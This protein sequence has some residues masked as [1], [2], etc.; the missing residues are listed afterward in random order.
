VPEFAT[1]KDLPSVDARGSLDRGRGS[2][3]VVP[4]VVGCTLFMQTLDSTVVATAL[5]AMARSLHENPA[6]INIVITAYLLSLAVFIPLSA[7]LANKFGARS[8]FQA[9]IAIFTIGSILCGLS[10]SLTEIIAARFLQGLGG[11][12]MLPVGR[13][14]V[15]KTLPKTDWVEAISYLTV[16]AMLGPVVGPPL[17]G[18]IVTYSTW[19]WIFL[20]NVPVGL[21]GIALVALVV[22]NIREDDVPALD[23]GGFALSAFGLLGLVLGLESIGRGILPAAAVAGAMVVGAVCLGLYAIHARRAAHPIIDVRLLRIPTFAVAIVG[24]G[25]FRTGIEAMPFLLTMLFQVGFG[26]SPFVSGVFTFFSAACALTMKMAAM[27]IV[28]RFGFRSLLTVN[29][30]NAATFM[31]LCALFRPSTPY[32]LIIGTL[33]VGGFFRSLQFTSVAALCYADVPDKLM[34]EASTLASMTHQV[35]MSLGV[36]LA[37]LVLNVS[38]AA[39]RTSTLSVHDISPAFLALGAVSLLGTVVFTRLNRDAGAELRR[40]DI[41]ARHGH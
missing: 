23:V 32:V 9:A 34:G 19:R 27:P 25:L 12:M 2:R 21:L 11:A 16:P 8:V 26:L 10:Q 15:L 5:P 40:P 18:L 1:H 6:R 3:F 29:C 13:L 24:G 39:G 20:I 7:W 22:R 37:A 38:L 33:L 41:L 17:G 28:R 14:L 36:T 31:M 4:L 35:F 30:I